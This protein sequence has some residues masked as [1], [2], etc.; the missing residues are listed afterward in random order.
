MSK[1]IPDTTWVAA[2]CVLVVFTLLGFIIG[3]AI[4]PKLP[5][6]PPPPPISSH[7]EEFYRSLIDHLIAYNNTLVADITRL[8]AEKAERN[9]HALPPLGELK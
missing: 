5:N 7:D 9:G 2:I 4:H 8:E 3:N 1:L 6:D